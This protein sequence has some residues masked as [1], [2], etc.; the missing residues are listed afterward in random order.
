MYG[1][2]AT[3]AMMAQP[4]A[5]TDGRRKHLIKARYTGLATKISVPSTS[6]TSPRSLGLKSNLVDITSGTPLIFPLIQKPQKKLT[7]E[8]RNSVTLLA[9][10]ALP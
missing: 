3:N 8:F 1:K 2:G 6:D 4:A 10:E 7:H 5:N 9:L